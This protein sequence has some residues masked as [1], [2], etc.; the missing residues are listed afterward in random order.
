MKSIRPILSGSAITLLRKSSLI[1]AVAS[2]GLAT[3]A[4]SQ[5]IT[6]GAATTMSADADV[7]TT[8]AHDR[9][10]IFNGTSTIN[11]VSFT[12]FGSSGDT[13][14]FTSGNFHGGYNPNSGPV[15]PNYDNLSAAYKV[16]AN[17]GR[18]SNDGNGAITLNNLNAGLDYTV[19]VWVSDSRDFGAGTIDVR[20]QTINGSPSLDFNVQ[21]NTGGVGQFVTGTFTASGASTTLTISANASAQINA[22]N[23][24]ATGVTAGNTATITTPRNWSALTLGVGST[25]DY[26]LAADATQATVVSGT[27]TFVKSGAGVLTL[28]EAQTYD[29]ATNITGGTLRLQGQATLAVLGAARQFDA[30]TLGLA[31]GANVSQWNDVSGNGQNATVPGGNGTPTFIAN[32]GTGTGLGA[33][34]FTAGTN[35]TDSQALT[36]TRDTNVRTVFSVFKGSSFLLTDSNNYGFHRPTDG[37]PADPL[38]ANYGGDTAALVGGSTFVNGAQVN[39]ETFAMPTSLNNGYNLVSMTTNGGAVAVNGF[40]KDRIYHAGNQSQAEVLIYDTVLS[41]AQRQHNEAY[42]QKKWFGTTASGFGNGALPATTPVTISNAGV[43]DLNNSDQTIGSLSSTDGSGT[44]VILSAGTLTVGNA[45]NTTFDGVISGEG[46]LV[47]QGTGKLTL[48]GANTYASLTVVNAGTLQLGNGST[49]NGS[50]A[51][52]VRTNATLAFANPAAQTYAGI[53]SGTGVVEK[54]GAGALTLG[55]NNSFSGGLTV[56]AG[57]LI[58]GSDAALGAN[59]GSVVVQSGASLDINGRALQGYTQNIQIAG[60]GNNATLG[61]LGNSGAQNLNAI[62]G[63]TLTADAS[64]GGDGGRWDIGRLDFNADPNNTVD[65]IN[66]GGF[67]LTKVGN[68]HLGLLTGAS[69]LAG[70]SINGGTVAPH[71]NT[72]FGAGTVTLNNGATI[73]PWGGLNVANALALNAGTIR[74]DGFSDNYN[75]PAAVNGPVT[76]N[77]V[78]GGNITFNGNITGS[79]AITK[80]GGYSF[81]LAGDNSGFTGSVTNNESNVFLNSATAGSADAAFTLNAGNLANTTAGTVTQHL[82]SLAGTGGNLGNNIAGSAVTFSVGENDSSTAFSGNIV[83]TVGGGGTTAIKKVGTGTFTFAGAATHS[84]GTTVEAGTLL[85]S[86]SISGAIT[87][88]SGAVLGGSGGSTGAI[89]VESGGTLA[90]G[91]SPGIL[92]TTGTLDLAGGATFSLELNGTT[93]GTGYDQMIVGGDISLGG[94]TLSLSL[95]FAPNDGDMFTILLNNGTNPIG[96]TFTGLA[97]GA[98]FTIG[99]ESFSISYVGGDG[100]DVVLTAV[101]EPGSAVLLLGGL[102]MLGARRRRKA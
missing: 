50:I 59:S 61:A 86:G 75:G 44:Q 65:H 10:Y 66:G 4:Y 64:I 8:G 71:E 99:A 63:I 31:D 92:S 84:D 57:T 20:T 90:P 23:L 25:L 83:D 33:I 80:T 12:S 21:N 42:L 95:G 55:G 98:E 7:L 68:S 100:N 52:S 91:A 26:N 37:N 101:P 93:A 18:Y 81:F 16:I 74:T 85:V 89:T 32:A 56:A 43:L 27:G 22:L 88:K 36:F 1:F 39:P 60:A 5:S 94:S 47:K 24:R 73:Q 2:I 40:N 87:V 48:T 41:T 51:G 19:Q 15:F 76:I 30:S 49:T 45:T 9:A 35:A 82:G 53:I 69:N 79:G 28:T 58:A 62:R 54:S 78:T 70:F 3:S 38:L 77:A 29:G 11:G 34:N 46:S 13:D 67:T 14:G 97:N 17:N 102:A 72:S 96:G 6:W